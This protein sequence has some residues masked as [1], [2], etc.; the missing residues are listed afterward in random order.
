[1]RGRRRDLR[2]RGLDGSLLV[3][4][5]DLRLAL[6]LLP[7]PGR[8]RR[9]GEPLQRTF[10]VLALHLQILQLVLAAALQL[11]LAHASLGVGHMRA[12]ARTVITQWGCCNAAR[13]GYLIWTA[14]AAARPSG[15][16]PGRRAAAFRPTEGR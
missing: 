15:G 14:T 2:A 5:V 1:M 10:A 11:A 3:V 8:G 7:G 13:V 16:R 9:F 4:L 12:S 6:V